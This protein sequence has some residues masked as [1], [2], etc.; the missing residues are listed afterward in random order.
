MI[1]LL[2]VGGPQTATAGDLRHRV[3]AG[4]TLADIAKHYYGAAWKAVYIQAR[5]DISDARQVA[6]GTRLYVP[7]CWVYTVRRGDSAAVIAKRYLGDANR[8]VAVMQ[9]NGIKDASGLE[10]GSELLMPFHLR[11]IVESGDTL[12][13]ISRRYYR[14][15]RLANMIRDYNGAPQLTPG[16]RLT[17]PIFD[18]ATI[19]VQSRRYTPPASPAA[20]V[21]ASPLAN[22][23]APTAPSKPQPSAPEEPEDTSAA[24]SAPVANDD[25]AASVSAELRDAIGAYRRGEFV[26]GCGALETLLEEGKVG[27]AER[28]LLVSHL[29]FCAVAFGD[30]RAA[31]DYFRSWVEIDPRATLNP[32]TTSPKILNVFA[33]VAEAAKSSTGASP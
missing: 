14:S 24:P 23:P 18:R 25:T 11:H 8:Y 9:A 13:T 16:E 3:G 31:R 20:P 1:L 17:V 5:N 12:A 15:T 7:G 30:T 33:E 32:I 26:V 28:A 22:R 21:A 27:T 19:D 29:G 10:V 2:L 4:E 6:P